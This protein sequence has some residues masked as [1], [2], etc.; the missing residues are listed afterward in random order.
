MKY[1]RY[2]LQGTINYYDDFRNIN[3]QGE[4]YK[5]HKNIFGDLVCEA[6]SN[7]ILVS[8]V[9][10]DVPTITVDESPCC[11]HTLSYNGCEGGVVKW[12]YGGINNENDPLKSGT[13]NNIEQHGGT[14]YFKCTK[15]GCVSK[16]AQITTADK[17]LATDPTITTHSQTIVNGASIILSAK[18]CN[19]VYAWSNGSVGQSIVVNPTQTTT[20]QLTCKTNSCCES[21][22]K[23]SVTITVVC[24]TNITISGGNTAT[25]SPTIV[26]SASG[27]DSY[28]WS[29]GST[30]SSI[31]VDVGNKQDYSVT[32]SLNGCMSDTKSVWVGKCV[33]YLVSKWSPY[34]W[35]ENHINCDGTPGEKH[36]FSLLP[37]S[38][39][40]DAVKGTVNCQNCTATEVIYGPR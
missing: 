6:T 18:G 17:P 22:K 14:T 25:T 40:I 35:N 34:N 12:W 36:G 5:S 7:K 31:T 28:L 3:A 8:T 10:A 19:G 13:W 27:A 24:K 15:E 37:G 26:L 30:S 9:T 16:I 39:Y 32:G 20:Y 1:I 4:Y 23:P 21:I 29:N 33:S 11:H 38:Y 2:N